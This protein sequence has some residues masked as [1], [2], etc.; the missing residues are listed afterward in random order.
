MPNEHAAVLATRPGL[1]DLVDRV[2][3]TL[4]EAARASL[5]QQVTQADLV[6]AEVL[7]GVQV[8]RLADAEGLWVRLPDLAE[9]MEVSDQAARV[10]TQV[11]LASGEVT[12]EGDIRRGVVLDIDGSRLTRSPTGVTMLS[13]RACLV[14]T[15]KC[16]GA[17]GVAFRAGLLRMLEAAA[18]LERACAVLLLERA[19][20]PAP[21]PVADGFELLR[22]FTDELLSRPVSARGDVVARLLRDPEAMDRIARAAVDDPRGRRELSACLI[23]LPPRS[24]RPFRDYLDWR[25][26]LHRGQRRLLAGPS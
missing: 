6:V 17:R 4:P 22:A 13:L 20:A 21:A 26:R 3:A 9:V 23:A 11:A 24:V 19:T 14:L 18:E 8:W 12:E 10:Q 1:A 5:D 7:H 2:R 15:M 16:Q 25:M